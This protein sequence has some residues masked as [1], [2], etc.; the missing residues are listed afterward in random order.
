[1]LKKGKI[2]IFGIISIFKQIEIII[3]SW[4]ILLFK[5]FN[6]LNIHLRMLAKVNIPY[7]EPRSISSIIIKFRLFI[8]FL[9]L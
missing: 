5:N 8:L 6:H 7:F 3:K 9:Q 1:M 2:Q 4:F